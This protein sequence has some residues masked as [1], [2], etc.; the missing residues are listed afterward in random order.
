MRFPRG[1]RIHINFI[2]SAG[3]P[4]IKRKL[5]PFYFQ[6]IYLTFGA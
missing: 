5:Q 6:N 2:L 1:K 3:T 4:R